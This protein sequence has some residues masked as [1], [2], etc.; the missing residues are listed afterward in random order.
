MPSDDIQLCSA[1]GARPGIARK[2]CRAF[3]AA[4]RQPCRGASALRGRRNIDILTEKS[5]WHAVFKWAQT[6]VMA[7]PISR[8]GPGRATMD[9]AAAKWFT[10]IRTREPRG[11][12]NRE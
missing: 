4:R 5:F 10:E 8:S 11:P 6:S 2:V 3:P 7:V 1:S 9:G 12:F